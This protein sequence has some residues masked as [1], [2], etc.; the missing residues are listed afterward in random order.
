MPS[1]A[2]SVNAAPA[3]SPGRDRAHVW[4]ALQALRAVAAAHHDRVT[5]CSATPVAANGAGK[6]YLCATSSMQARPAAKD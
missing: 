5:G 1:H 6:V 2:Y 4:L 3:A